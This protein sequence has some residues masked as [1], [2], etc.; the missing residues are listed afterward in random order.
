MNPGA[1]ANTAQMEC[2]TMKWAIP[3]PDKRGSHA[4]QSHW[5]HASYL[6]DQ[7]KLYMTDL[8]SVFL[9]MLIILLRLT[10]T[11]SSLLLGAWSAILGTV[12]WAMYL[13]LKIYSRRAEFYQNSIFD[14][15]REA[16]WQRKGVLEKNNKK[17]RIKEKTCFSSINLTTLVSSSMSKRHIT[18]EI[19]S[20][21]S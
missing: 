6:A 16:K 13:K 19:A 11:S 3:P 12:R 10:T 1:L 7:W 17:E 5:S 8:S 18:A 9:Q 20:E 4:H 15:L 14:W 2:G 21:G